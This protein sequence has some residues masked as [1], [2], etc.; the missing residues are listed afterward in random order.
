MIAVMKM[1]ARGVDPQHIK[2]LT[3]LSPWKTALALI[4]DWA[5]IGLAISL[6]ELLAHPLAYL[7]AVLVIAGRIH[8]IAVIIHEFA[9]FRF[10]ADRRVADWIGNIFAAWP[11]GTTI[12]GYR[13]SHFAHHR[14]T[15][16]N[17]DPDWAIKFGTPQFTFP[18]PRR[19]LVKTLLG[20]FT[21]VSSIRDIR[22]FLARFS[23]TSDIPR[24]HRIA[25]LGFIATALLIITLSGSWLGFAMYWLIPY[26]SFYLLFFYVRSVAEH[27]GAMDYTVELGN[28]RTVLPRVWERWFFAPHG[29]GYHLDHH[30]YPSVPFYNLPELHALLLADPEY[31]KRAHITRGY[32]TGVLRECLPNSG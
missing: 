1:Y 13:R 12:E 23:Q 24:S 20:Y 7:V 14:H 18:Q 17:D 8:A 3:A 15:N 10:I 2:R 5:M 19:T 22:S 4:V 32:L 29:I 30:L 6:S 16:T 21:L 25:R 26:L 27:F 9:H 28:S 31:A 11:L